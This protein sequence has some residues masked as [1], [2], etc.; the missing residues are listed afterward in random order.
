MSGG[1]STGHYGVD[2]NARRGSVAGRIDTP[3]GIV[4]VWTKAAW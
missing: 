4:T 1:Q 2:A 3:C